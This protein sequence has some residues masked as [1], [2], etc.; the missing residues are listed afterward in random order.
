M[1]L[2]AP[3][4]FAPYVRLEL[5]C[6][7]PL[8]CRAAPDGAASNGNEA[9]SRSF[10]QHVWYQQLFDYGMPSDLSAANPEDPDADLV[11]QLV[12]KLVLPQVRGALFLWT[13]L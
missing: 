9:S 3:A 4:L 6:W 5:L 2:S 10:D 7:D 12:K 8:Y 1:H 11:P 13:N